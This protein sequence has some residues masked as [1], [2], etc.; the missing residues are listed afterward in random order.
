MPL[1]MWLF[2]CL[3]ANVVDNSNIHRHCALCMWL[4]PFCKNSAVY[5]EMIVESTQLWHSKHLEPAMQS[6]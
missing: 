4:F 6:I 2:L 1:C 5:E 3:F